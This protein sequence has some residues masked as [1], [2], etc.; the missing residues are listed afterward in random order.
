MNKILRFISISHKTATVAQRERYFISEIEKEAIYREI[1]TSFPDV[2]GLLILVTCNRTEFYF[3]SEVASSSQMLDFFIAKKINAQDA[4]AP[5]LFNKSDNT[6]STLRH[7]LTVSSGLSSQVLGDADIVHQIK[8]AFRQSI[9][10]Q[11]QGSLLE[12]AMQSVFKAHKR[13]S[14]E[15]EFRDGTTSVAYKALKVVL[16]TFRGDH[17]VSKKIL[18]IGTGDIVKQLLKYNAKFNFSNLHISKINLML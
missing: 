6:A 13:I 17:P 11:L 1:K 8:K 9:G 5:G 18:M 4:S 10:Y 12:R 14:N 15:T 7:L 16:E 2:S 3:E